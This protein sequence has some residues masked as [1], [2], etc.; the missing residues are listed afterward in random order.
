[1]RKIL[2][3]ISVFLALGTVV[4][5]AET[6]D[7]STWA[8]FSSFTYTGKA[9]AVPAADEYLNPVIGGFFPDPSIC[10]AGDDYYVV[11]SSF[12]YFPAIPIWHSKD[13]VN[14]TQIGHVLDRPSQFPMTGGAVQSGTYAPTI[15]YHE[16]TFYLICTLVGGM[17]NF[18]V[19]ATDPAGPWSEPIQLEGVGGID[20]DIFFD[21]DGKCYI[22]SCDG[23]VG[24]AKYSGHRT[25][26]IQEYDLEQ[27]KPV[28]EK[29]LIVDG[30]TDITKEPNW[31]EAPPYL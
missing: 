3:I 2:L 31:C 14:W 8:Q 16:G 15:R 10:R 12:N 19:T 7:T 1:M 24:Q 21:D 25:I 29:T 27:N 5:A 4:F 18:Y 28:G 23:P 30:G 22:S 9:A 17:G 13:L 26:R 20:P 11:N 6:P